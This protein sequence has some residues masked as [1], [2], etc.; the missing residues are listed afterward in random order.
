MATTQ[1]NS[2]ATTQANSRA[3]TQANNMTATQ[4]NS[5][6][7]T[8][9]NS[10]AT[11]QANNMAATQANSRATTQANN[12]TATQA[13]SRATT[14]ANNMTATQANSMTATQANSRAATQANS[15]ATT[16]ANNMTA[17]QANSRATTQANNMTT[18]QANSRATTQANSMTATQANNMTATQANSRA[19]TQAN[20]MTATQ[21]NS[22]AAT[23]A[24]SR[25][26]TQANN[27]T[28]TQA[29]SRATTQANNMT[30]TQANSRATTQANSK[31]TTQANNMTATQANSKATTQANNM[32]ATQANSRATTQANSK[33]T[34]Q[35]NSRATTQA[36]S[37]ATT[38]ANSRA[39][40]QAN[41]KVTTQANSRAATQANS[42]ATTQA[43][44][45]DAVGLADVVVWGSLYPLISHEPQL[46][47]AQYEC[48]R[49]WHTSIARHEAFQHGAS[50]ANCSPTSFKSSGISITKFH[51]SS[52]EIT[53][54]VNAWMGSEGIPTAR[55]RSHPIYCRI[56]GYN[57]LYISGTDE[58]GTATETKALEEGLTPKEIC[59]KYYKIHSDVYSWF[60]IEFDFFGRTTTEEQT[61]YLSITANYTDQWEKW[62][63]NPQQ[64]TSY[65]FM[66]K[67]NVPFHTVVFPST[68][69]GADDNY[70]LLNSISATE[71]L[72]YEDDKFS[73]SRGVG[74]FG[75]NAQAS[76]IPADIWR[77]YLLYMRP[78][79]QVDE[80]A[81]VLTQHFLPVLKP[82]H[83]IGQPKPLFQKIEP[84]I[85]D[86]LKKKF[87]GQRKETPEKP[88]DSPTVCKGNQDIDKLQSE[89]T[90]QGEKIRG[91]KANKADKAVID[92]EV[93]RLLDMK[94]QFALAQG[95]D[96]N[97]AP[98]K[99]KKKTKKKISN[100]NRRILLGFLNF[101]GICLTY[102]EIVS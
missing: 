86:E 9:A 4:A 88:S 98:S 84:S 94:K 10:R 73:K 23:Q 102:S 54:A 47:G 6:T 92:A 87:A 45:K 22:R 24:N 28:A 56:N 52:D 68:L 20:S 1:A 78:E 91:L 31:V 58:Y 85:A 101:L 2:K 26:T 46:L 29:N 16:Q 37:R 75:D 77:F 40:T 82:G 63:K 30:A 36:N 35:A 39:T 15:R 71:Y 14:Q 70:T 61:K 62:W 69:L 7:A 83:K 49:K 21:A 79:G 95:K 64:V 93:V 38:Q 3:T 41:S 76:G 11:T 32:T 89:V 80:D 53:E 48:L 72:N 55:K 59:D 44:S 57:T 5:M 51:A 60:N 81:N 19:T 13:N 42:R 100:F 66:A 27:M 18:T 74:V 50:E 8:Q 90:A 97:S 33:A 25:A 65:Q 99:G 17:R 96:P 43:N 67:D 12:M 34:T